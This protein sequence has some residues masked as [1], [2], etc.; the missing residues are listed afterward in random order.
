MCRQPPS[1]PRT[2]GAAGQPPLL[3][4][5]RKWGARRG[6]LW[7]RAHLLGCSGLVPHT[8]ST[9]GSPSPCPWEP[10]MQRVPVH[11]AA[12]SAHPHA[13]ELIGS[14]AVTH[15]LC[16]GEFCGTALWTAA[17]CL[18]GLPPQEPSVAGM[19]LL[20]AALLQSPRA[21]CGHAVHF[22]C[23][24]FGL[25][26]TGEQAGISSLSS[27]GACCTCGQST[28][29]QSNVPLSCKVTWRLKQNGC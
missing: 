10:C 27:G 4:C 2:R 16:T 13:G 20:P 12:G 11:T 21:W 3:Q 26:V 19:V 14:A 8:P 6:P 1:S 9:A 23:R 25:S 28:C 22:A 24:G 18:D 7:T 29:T 17:L 15:C 5:R